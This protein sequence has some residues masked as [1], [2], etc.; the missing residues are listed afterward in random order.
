[1]TVADWIEAV[2]GAAAVI[3]AAVA[4]WQARV[5]AAAAR[6]SAKASED[7]VQAGRDTVNEMRRQ[8]EDGVRRARLHELHNVRRIVLRL[9]TMAQHGQEGTMEFRFVQD[10]LRSALQPPIGTQ[11]LLACLALAEATMNETRHAE[12]ALRE[13]DNV[14]FALETGG[15]E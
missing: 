8:H 6:V 13:I 5:S 10:E 9:Q 14:I 7:T 11:E 3:V 2:I 4:A 15:P 12:E 1:M